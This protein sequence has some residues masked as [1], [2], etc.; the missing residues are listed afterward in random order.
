MNFGIRPDHAIISDGGIYY[1]AKGSEDE[2]RF[3]DLMGHGIRFDWQFVTL[4][5]WFMGEPRPIKRTWGQIRL[6]SDGYNIAEYL[7]DILQ[8]YP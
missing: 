3:S 6:R 2:E 8:R 7:H 1:Y 4:N 5:P